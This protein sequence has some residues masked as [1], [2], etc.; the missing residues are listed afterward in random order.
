MISVPSQGL[1]WTRF[2]D[3]VAILYIK[4]VH[5]DQI[6][7]LFMPTYPVMT[8]EKW[9]PRAIF[10]QMIMIGVLSFEVDT[11]IFWWTIRPY[12]I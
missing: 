5:N 10:V 9:A 4:G 3:C 6:I 11:D 8:P 7:H 12:Y 1:I 2:V